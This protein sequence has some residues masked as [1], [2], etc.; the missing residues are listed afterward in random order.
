MAIGVNT[1]ACCVGNMGSEHRFDYSILGDSVNLA[2]RLAEMAAARD[3]DL[4]LG[5]ATAAALPPAWFTLI[6][7]VQVKGRAQ[8]VRVFTVDPPMALG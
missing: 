4:A 7:T 3:I 2:A 8:T 1:G 5:E 6:D